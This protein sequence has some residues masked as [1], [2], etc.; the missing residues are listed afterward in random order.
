MTTDITTAK[1][2]RHLR[3][4]AIVLTTAVALTG[5]GAAAA[6]AETPLGT[7][8][9]GTSGSGPTMRDV[10]RLVLAAGAPGYV[11]RI[12]DGRRVSATAA[13][14]ADRAT[15]RPLTARDQFEIGSNTK[16]F[17]AV[18]AL[19]LIDRRQLQLDAPIEKYLPGLV[20]NG[21]NITVRMLLSHTS[22]LFSYTADADFF[23]SVNANPQHVHTEQELLDVAFR[24]EP[25]FAPGKGWSYSNTNYT[26]LGVLLRKLTGKSLPVLVQQRITGP[27]GLKHTYFADPRATNTGVGYAHGY[28]V[29]F[30]GPE[31]IYTDI[32]NR[33]LG[34]FAGAAGAIISTPGELS[35]F[36]SSLLSGE[37]ISPRQLKEMKTTVALPE[38]FGKGGYGL[39]LMRI[40]SPCGSVWG[41]GGDTLGHHSTAV[42]TGN[43]RRSAVSN[44]TANLGDGTPNEGVNRFIQVVTAADTV[45]ICHMLGRSAPGEVIKALHGGSMTT[46]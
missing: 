8:A 23:A 31:P 12:D 17:T 22:G 14:V 11:A 13:G 24:H 36:F 9:Y 1:A 40:D 34:G 21:R 4:T 44:T 42:T 32:S 35:R 2:M 20:P 15:G 25:N 16:T 7:G 6:A 10:A 19:Q 33:P 26:V 27:L 43:G 46:S 29:R 5:S 39:G 28:S 45:T 37:L 18:L 41:H 30:A 3:K 38:T